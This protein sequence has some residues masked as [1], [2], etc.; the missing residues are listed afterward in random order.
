MHDSTPSGYVSPLRSAVMS[1]PGAQTSIVELKFE[2]GARCRIK[3]T[4][5]T[6]TTELNAAGEP[7]CDES[8]LPAAATS[9]TPASAAA[10]H[11]ACSTELMP[12]PPRLMLRM[13]ARCVG[14]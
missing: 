9:N 10:S 14:S 3:S 12:G 1:P 2:Y 11:A 13:S 8:S 4:A 5:P 6:D 7:G